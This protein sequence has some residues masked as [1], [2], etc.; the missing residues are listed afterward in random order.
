MTEV[1]NYS[2]DGLPS[3][4]TIG[5]IVNDSLQC[6]GHQFDASNNLKDG[7]TCLAVWRATR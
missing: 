2:V 6:A 5:P 1:L 3:I 4:Y 7:W